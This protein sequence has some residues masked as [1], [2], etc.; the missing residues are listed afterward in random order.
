MNWDQIERKWSAMTM[1]VRVDWGGETGKEQKATG[2]SRGITTV[3][4]VMV[5]ET[6]PER[7]VTKQAV[8]V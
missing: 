2:S 8:R 1:R 3:A 5:Q 4:V 7:V 6:G